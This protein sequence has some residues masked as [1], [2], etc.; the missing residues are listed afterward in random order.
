MFGD[1][2]LYILLILFIADIYIFFCYIRK[3]TDKNPLRALWFLPLIIIGGAVYIFF[4]KRYLG[5]Y[6][7]LFT[8]VYIALALPQ[9]IF[10]VISLPDIPLRLFVK[11]R[12]YP[13]TALALL[14]A[15]GTLFIIVYGATIG[16]THFKVREVSYESKEIPKS[17]DGYKIV[18]VSDLHI[19]N[20]KDKRAAMEKMVAMINVQSADLV[21]VTGDLVHHRATEFDGVEDIL[22]RIEAKE[23]VF[24]IMGNH[25]Y[26]SY[27]R[28][29][30]KEE[31]LQNLKELKLRQSKM[32]WEML[33][34]EHCIISK[35]E[36]K[37]A[38]IGVENGGSQ[39]FA[40]YSN[41][42]A[43]MKGI[44]NVPFKILLSHDPTHWRREVIGTGIDITLSGH[45]HGAQFILFGL[46][47]SSSRYDEWGGVYMEGDQMLYVNV[48]AGQTGLAFRFGAWPEVTVI[49]LK[50]LQ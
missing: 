29:A 7:D 41:L 38:I 42:P 31:E 4:V 49:T 6:R 30:N 48:G 39:G 27:R 32:G 22:S 34:N 25:D 19:G 5:E 14:S 11:W 23:R 50:N 28:F 15:A 20:W 3:L 45:T 26:G 35:G 47:P 40:D 16:T 44:T 8:L 36:D 9:I 24:S 46:S 18:Q 37:I 10:A 21:M 1:A 13:F 43:A 2:F 12:V 33:N 17:F